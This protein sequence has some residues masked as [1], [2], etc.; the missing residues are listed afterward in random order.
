MTP[1]PPCTQL[2]VINRK[3]GKMELFH[4]GR[5]IEFQLTRL[6][7]SVRSVH[8]TVRAQMLKEAMDEI[9]RRTCVK[10]VQNDDNLPDYVFFK[11][12][13]GRQCSSEIGR[14]GRLFFHFFN[15]MLSQRPNSLCAEQKLAY[16][17]TE[18]KIGE[19]NMHPQV[20][21]LHDIFHNFQ[22]LTKL[23]T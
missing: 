3:D 13:P 4:T 6:G 20:K 15:N 10:F 7:L 18:S 16:R 14:Q 2:S 23:K 8:Y 1:I 12:P 11:A 21:L 19:N 17:H 9:G 22:K 5:D